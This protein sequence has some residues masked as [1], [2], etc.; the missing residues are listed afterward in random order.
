MEE[1]PIFRM[2]QEQKKVVKSPLT[3][4]FRKSWRQVLQATFLVAVTYTLFYTLATWSLAWGT[5]EQGEGGGNLGFTN[6]EYLLMLMI[7]ICVFALFIVLSCLYADKIGRRRVLTFSSCALVVFAVLFPF[8][9][10]GG[11]VGQ[12]NFF[13]NMV[14][15]CVGFALMG[16]AFGPICAFLPEL[17][18]ANVRYSGSGIGY[19]LAAIVG[20][21]FVPTIA[22]WLSSHWGV[23]SVGLYLAVMAVCCLVSVLTCKETKDVDFT[24]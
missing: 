21:A 16:I 23:H 12:K 24:K 18:D 22:T 11:L 8:L 13:A 1:T 6:Q 9:L 19:N 15:L 3:E 5:K 4:V 2:A 20:A 10:D 7:S 14:F 17:F